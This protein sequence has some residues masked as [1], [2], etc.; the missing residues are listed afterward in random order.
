MLPPYVRSRRG[1]IAAGPVE[2]AAP[3]GGQ[4]QGWTLT[5]SDP[6]YRCNG[7]QQL[8]AVDGG[9]AC[10]LWHCP[11]RHLLRAVNERFVACVVWSY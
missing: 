9:A 2:G 7:Q 8:G 1:R 3:L 10:E 6:R 5:A 4:V 11:N